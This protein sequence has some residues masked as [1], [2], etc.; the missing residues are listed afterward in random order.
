MNLLFQV[1]KQSVVALAGV[2]AWFAV[3]SRLCAQSAPVISYTVTGKFASSPVSGTDMFKLAGKPFSINL[4]ASEGTKPNTSAPTYATYTNLKAT[5]TVVSGL[6]LRSPIHLSSPHA[7]LALA[8]GNPSY[9]VVEM[10]IP[11][12][13][14][15][16]KITI[17]AKFLVP[18]GTFTTT[19]IGPF[20][21]AAALTTANATVAYSDGTNATTLAVASGGINAKVSA[22]AS[23]T[24]GIVG[25]YPGAGRA[26]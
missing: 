12:S 7:F 10:V 24:T 22:A 11:V 17:T 16:Q 18:H 20:S 1:R 23:T 14:A 21:A 13:V 4:I 6:L 8:L 26:F 9:D 3:S 19:A 25:Y 15:A 2:L 5:G